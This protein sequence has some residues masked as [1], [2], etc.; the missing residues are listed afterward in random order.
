MPRQD[1]QTSREI[2]LRGFNITVKL[3]KHRVKLLF[4]PYD[5]TIG[6]NEIA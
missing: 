2:A 4:G 5:N 6:L 1:T 3:P